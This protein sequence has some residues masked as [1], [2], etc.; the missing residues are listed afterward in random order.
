MKAGKSAGYG[1][2]MTVLLQVDVGGTWVSC[3]DH[4]L[5]LDMF[6]LLLNRDKATTVTTYFSISATDSAEEYAAHEK[7]GALPA[8]SSSGSSSVTTEEALTSA[9]ATAPAD[10]VAAAAVEDAPHLS[11]ELGGSDV[12]DTASSAEPTVEALP[13]DAAT[14][15][16]R[17]AA[18]VAEASPPPDLSQYVEE[19]EATPLPAGGALMRTRATSPATSTTSGRRQKKK[20]DPNTKRTAKT[21]LEF[22]KENPD[23]WDDKDHRYLV[24][25]LQDILDAG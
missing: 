18:A 3:H 9:A 11:A 19:S 22:L 12:K 24:G 23:P 5:A 7:E 6:N 16:V 8:S 15:V 13:A 14:P 1:L 21:A 4:A 10:E 17:E 25:V 2:L 20:R